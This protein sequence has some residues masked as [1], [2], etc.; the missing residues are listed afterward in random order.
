MTSQS[1]FQIRKYVPICESSNS[2]IKQFLNSEF[3]YK[4]IFIRTDYQSNGK[5]QGDNFWESENGKN[6]LVSFAL[7]PLNLKASQQFYLS[8]WVANSIIDLL[9]EYLDRDKLWIK[10]P[11]DIYY[12]NRKMAGI[13]IENS[14]MGEN[15]QYSIVGIGL[16]VNQTQFHSSAPNPVSLIHLLNREVA[17]KEITDKLI[18]IL[19]KVDDFSDENFLEYLD[20]YYLNKLYW[21]GEKHLFRIANKNQEAIILGIDEFG[22]LKLLVDNETQVF[23]IKEVIYIR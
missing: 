23:D 20:N 18:D 6:M 10:W 15:I 12:E 16:N 13:L 22:F 14:V 21:Q 9:R 19:N 1:L 2:Y 3:E 5:G 4:N 17:L 8:K 7:Y 11:N